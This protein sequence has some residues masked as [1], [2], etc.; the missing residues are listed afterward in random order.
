MT[1]LLEKTARFV[2]R[3]IPALFVAMTTLLS[4][5][6]AGVPQGG[7]DLI[8]VIDSSGSMKT[9]DQRQA[10][11]EVAKSLVGLLGRGD[12]VAVVS[13]SDAGYPLIGL[14]PV[15]GSA[16]RSKINQ[17]IGKTSSKG[18][19]SNIP[20]ALATAAKVFPKKGDHRRQ[21]AIVL[22]SDGRI[23]LNDENTTFSLTQRLVRRSIPQLVKQK[24]RVFTISFA[25]D[26]NNALLQLLADDTKGEFHLIG[27]HRIAKP[28]LE[29]ILERARVRLGPALK[30]KRVIV[31]EGTQ[32]MTVIVP[33][34]R[35][36][37]DI[38][39]QSPTGETFSPSDRR[40]KIRWKMLDESAAARIARPAPGS[41][42]VSFPGSK[43]ITVIK[44]PILRFAFSQ[45]DLSVG[46]ELR[47]SA[48]LTDAETLPA[49]NPYIKPTAISAEITAPDGSVA[50]LNL[51]DT[52]EFG[53]ERTDD[54]RFASAI[55]FNI[56]GRYE[57]KL[58]A[59]N[60][61]LTKRRQVHLDV[62]PSY[63]RE[64]MPAPRDEA[65]A[66]DATPEHR[67]LHPIETAQ[68][69]PDPTEVKTDS[70]SSGFGAGIVLLLLS[71]AGAGGLYWFWKYKRP[72]GLGDGDDNVYR[73]L[74]T[75]LRTTIDTY[76]ARG[77]NNADVTDP[78]AEESSEDK[79]EQS[80]DAEAKPS[81]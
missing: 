69:E 28:V 35:Q 17:A 74:W 22:L 32:E 51:N 54:G 19:Y 62:A 52:G 55:V 11:V 76:K 14:T 65:A 48:W 13:F 38:Y 4:T 2:W 53:D 21:R 75:Q 67:D 66:M 16:N 9:S 60:R 34:D 26:S 80:P 58:M 73:W 33:R 20:G 30:D 46:T 10:R 6:E 37:A 18:L 81:V 3:H 56:P 50:R 31:A 39:L 47:L 77:K 72:E 45:P 24:V 71:A 57:L 5:A 78:G 44:D 70:G 15:S 29:G 63:M 61:Y 49:T 64:L 8:L 36:A 1:A 68:A 41:W 42:R 43:N 25:E 27:D 40:S 7:L 79:A 23:D 59:E 12:R